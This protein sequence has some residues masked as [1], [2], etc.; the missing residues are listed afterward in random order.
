MPRVVGTGGLFIDI[1]HL[2]S[3]DMPFFRRCSYVCM[4]VGACMCMGAN[5]CLYMSTVGA[6]KV[7]LQVQV[8]LAIIDYKN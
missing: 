3:M 7:V 6:I 5:I 2:L 1:V 8:A 4:Y